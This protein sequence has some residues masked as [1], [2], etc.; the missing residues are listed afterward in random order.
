MKRLCKILCLCVMMGCIHDVY[1]ADSIH[2][3]ADTSGMT[4]DETAGYG[5]NGPDWWVRNSLGDGTLYGVGLCYSPNWAASDPHSQGQ[6]K[7]HC[8]CRVISPYRSKWVDLEGEYVDSTPDG[9]DCRRECAYSCVRE[10]LYYKEE[11]TVN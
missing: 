1:A 7:T 2:F 5:A 6:E 11:F 4:D 9:E 8:K 10:F 3:C